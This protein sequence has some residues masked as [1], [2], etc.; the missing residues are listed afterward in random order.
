MSPVVLHALA[1]DLH[2][3]LALA[4]AFT[5]R[6]PPAQGVTAGNNAASDGKV[7]GTLLNEGSH[8]PF[9]IVFQ[10]VVVVG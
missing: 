8:L 1:E 4:L 3:G 5:G 2:R 7:A 10:G 9:R 6:R